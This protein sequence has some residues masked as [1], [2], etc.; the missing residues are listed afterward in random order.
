MNIKYMKLAYEE[1]LKAYSN[2]EIPIGAVIVKD[3]KVVSKGHNKKEK[4]CCAIYH[5]EIMAIEK[6]TKK[7][8]NW[9]LED[10]DIYITLEPCPMCAS[11]IKQSRIRNVYCA[12]S[13]SDKENFK[14]ISKIFERD[15]V[16]PG[17]N[18]YNDLD[19]ENTKLLM[20]KFFDKK[21]KK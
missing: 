2:D 5:A 15:C 7:I 12:L 14:I 6:A 19:V 9:R 1:A 21:R 10:C 17:V 11:A 16:N 13:N 8:G 4:K 18:I 3:D 20:Q